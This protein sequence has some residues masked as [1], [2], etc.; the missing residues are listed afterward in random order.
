MLGGRLIH[1]LTDLPELELLVAW[2]T[3]AP[4]LQAER[5]D[6]ADQGPWSW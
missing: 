1:L 4:A 2:R 6:P 3:L 5:P